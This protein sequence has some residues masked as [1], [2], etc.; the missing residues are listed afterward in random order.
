MEELAAWGEAPPLVSADSPARVLVSALPGFSAVTLVGWAYLG[1]G[2][3][4]FLA[5]IFT[6][7]FVTRTLRSG[8]SAVLAQVLRA[9]AGLAAL[10]AVSARLE[11]ERFEH[12][13]LEALRC[14]L[15]SG[16]RASH[17]IAALCSRVAWISPLQ[18]DFAQPAVQ[19]FG[20]ASSLAFSIERWRR[21]SGSHVR[22]WL[23]AVGAMEALCA[24]ASHAY[25]H[26]ADPFPELSEDGPVFDGVGLGHPLLPA[27]TCVR[28]DVL[29]GTG[30][31]ALLLLSGSNMSGK[32]TLLRTLGANAALAFSGAPVRAHRLRI[33]PLA[34]G[35]S[36]SARDSLLAGESRFYAEI[37]RLRQ[38]VSLLDG[39]VP[40][41]FLLDEILHGTNSHDRRQGAE[42]VLR[43]LLEGGAIGICTTHDLALA[44]I[45]GAI[46]DRCLNAHFGDVLENGKL[47]FDFK[48]REGVVRQSNAIELMRAVGLRV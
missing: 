31:P 12:P 29:L 18:N 27:D 45:A 8:V 5:A 40:V 10:A 22:R 1:W 2:P 34:I 36:L 24:L 21:E 11:S 44:E 9:H 46:G 42:G 25:E 35:A 32:S 47:H 37:V 30:G 20:G 3:A 7:V 17:R 13:R 43:G 16:G 26:A 19:L 4:P 33:S 39:S 23:E 38:I 14:E 15:F 41:L 6:S 48:L 28:N